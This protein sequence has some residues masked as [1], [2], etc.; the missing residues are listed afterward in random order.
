VIRAHLIEL[1][2]VYNINPYVN[3]IMYIVSYFGANQPRLKAQKDENISE[4]S[5]IFLNEKLPHFVEQNGKFWN[6]L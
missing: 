5:V 6:N 3:R 4:Y 2:V 1:F